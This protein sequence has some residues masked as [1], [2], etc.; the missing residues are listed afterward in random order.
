MA[1]KANGYVDCA[2]LPG[3]EC[4]CTHQIKEEKCPSASKGAI[5]CL[6]KGEKAGADRAHACDLIIKAMFDGK[7]QGKAVT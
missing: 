2:Y 6:A 3:G 5:V 4:D 7:Y 1:K